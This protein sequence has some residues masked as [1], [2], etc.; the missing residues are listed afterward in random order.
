MKV[1]EIMTRDVVT[2]GPE[3][4][5]RDVARILVHSR[6]SGLPVCGAGRALPGDISEA[7]ILPGRRGFGRPR[8]CATSSPAQPASRSP[9]AIA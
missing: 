9:S 2:I 4:D 1:Q 8:R 5:V 7:D 3:A 6:I